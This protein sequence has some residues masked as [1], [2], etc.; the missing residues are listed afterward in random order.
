MFGNKKDRNLEGDIGDLVK[1]VTEQQDQIDALAERTELLMSA[2]QSSIEAGKEAAAQNS[3][4]FFV[5]NQVVADIA[6]RDSR[7]YCAQ[8]ISLKD[9]LPGIIENSAFGETEPE[10]VTA[11]VL[12]I[13][14]SAMVL[15]KDSEGG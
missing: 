9:G 11:A 2:L 7:A 15:M 12:G 8:M 4:L 14:N 6:T 1:V 5:L 3:A 13:V 10:T